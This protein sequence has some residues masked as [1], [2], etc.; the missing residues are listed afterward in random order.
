MAV[1]MTAQGAPAR[2]VTYLSDHTNGGSYYVYRSQG[3]GGIM[4]DI[5]AI[6]NGMYRLS[7]TSQLKTEFGQSYLPVEVETYLMNRSGRAETGYF[8]PLE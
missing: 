2:E 4:Q 5:I 8:A 7:Y 1:V 6:P 3:L